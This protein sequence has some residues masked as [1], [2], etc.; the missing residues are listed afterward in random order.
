MSHY[1]VAEARSRFAEILD[2]SRDESVFIE[3]RGQQVAVVVSPE[4]YERMQAALEDAE[5]IADFDAA[6]AEGGPNIPWEQVKADLG[7]D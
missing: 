1:S 2:E 7:W 6:I 3:R 5:D 4:H